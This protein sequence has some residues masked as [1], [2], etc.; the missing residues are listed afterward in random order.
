[1]SGIAIRIE[2]FIEL[3][4]VF[5]ISNKFRN[6]RFRTTAKNTLLILKSPRVILIRGGRLLIG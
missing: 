6:L 3:I 2:D 4:K 5:L 1:M